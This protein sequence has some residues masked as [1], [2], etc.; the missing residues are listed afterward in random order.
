M[1]KKKFVPVALISLLFASPMILAEEAHH[2]EEGA[3]T[4]A[5]TE[6]VAKAKD[7]ES[8]TPAAPGG[9]MM[10]GPGMMGGAGGMMPGGKGGGMGMVG[11]KGGGMK[12]MHDKHRKLVGRLDLIEA[13]MTKIEFMLERL[14]L[15]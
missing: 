10:G 15:R 2:P 14:L 8:A 4:S 5:Q 1:I 6:P 3:A 7:S 9:M 13:R 11:G 12:G